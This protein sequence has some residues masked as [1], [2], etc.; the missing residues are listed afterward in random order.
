MAKGRGSLA[1]SAKR[2]RKAAL[3]SAVAFGLLAHPS[4]ASAANAPPANPNLNALGKA[5]LK[6]L[7][8]LPN[9]STNKFLSGQWNGYSDDP[10]MMS[11]LR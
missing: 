10:Y 6:Y 2:I 7:Q 3:A 9:K 4:I 11:T 5:W 8:D 1:A